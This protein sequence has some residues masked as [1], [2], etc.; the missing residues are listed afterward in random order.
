MTT[1]ENRPN[2][3][4]LVVDVQNDVVARA[5]ERDRVVSTIAALVDRDPD[6]LRKQYLRPLVQA[7]RLRFAF[8]T[9]PTH[10]MQA[11]RATQP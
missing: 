7:G 3:A 2:T 10:A 11:Y 8:P 1:L 9:A 5:H 4:L 6:A